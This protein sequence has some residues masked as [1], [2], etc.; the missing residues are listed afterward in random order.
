MAYGVF[1]I[2]RQSVDQGLNSVD[3]RFSFF[4]RALYPKEPSLAL[5]EFLQARFKN[6]EA[7]FHRRKSLLVAPFPSWRTRL[8]FLRSRRVPN[9]TLVMFTV[10]LL[11]SG[12]SNLRASLHLQPTCYR[13]GQ[14]SGLPHLA[15][16]TTVLR[17]G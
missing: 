11:M 9:F 12:S 7:G 16:F 6:I 14:G 3:P 5:V 13:L 15:Q 2:L 4:L 10:A 8:C 17:H 1:S